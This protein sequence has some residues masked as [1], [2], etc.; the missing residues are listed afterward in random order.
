MLYAC[1]RKVSLGKLLDSFL[2]LIKMYAHLLRYT[3]ASSSKQKQSYYCGGQSSMV[4]ILNKYLDCAFNV[5]VYDL[6]VEAATTVYL[7][8]CSC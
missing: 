6:Q 5:S 2:A 1:E 7:Q 8:K 4:E 3:T